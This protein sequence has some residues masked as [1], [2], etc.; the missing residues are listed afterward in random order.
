MRSV[1]NRGKL[2]VMGEGANVALGIAKSGEMCA[3][4]R[5]WQGGGSPPVGVTSSDIVIPNLISR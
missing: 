3:D 4:C 2:A 1:A 5:D